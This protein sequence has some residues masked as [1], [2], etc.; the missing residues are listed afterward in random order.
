MNLEVRNEVRQ[1]SRP[2]AK[3]K[4]LHSD[5]EEWIFRSSVFSHPGGGGGGGGGGTLISASAVPIA[6]PATSKSLKTVHAGTD[7]SAERPALA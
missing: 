7:G 4:K 3:H 6:I 2:Q 5:L 1:N